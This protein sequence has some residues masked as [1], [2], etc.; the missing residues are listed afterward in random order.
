MSNITYFDYEKNSGRNLNFTDINGEQKKLLFQSELG[1]GTFSSNA[2]YKDSKTDELFAFKIYKIKNFPKFYLKKE[3]PIDKVKK[4]CQFWARMVNDNIPRLYY[5]FQKGETIIAMSELGNLGEPGVWNDDLTEFKLKD[6]VYDLFWEKVIEEDKIYHGVITPELD[7]TKKASCQSEE[8]CPLTYE[9]K[10]GKMVPERHVKSN[11]SFGANVNNMSE[12]EMAEFAYD[13]DL[14]NDLDFNFES[15]E[16]NIMS[17]DSNMMIGSFVKKKSLIL[18]HECSSHSNNWQEPEVQIHKE[19]ENLCSTVKKMYV[20]GRIFWDVCVGLYYMHKWETAHFD[21]KPN[22]IVISTKNSGKAMLIDFNTVE[23][24][25]ADTLFASSELEGTKI[26]AA[27]EA[28]F[29]INFKPEKYDMWGL[30]AVLY[31]FYYGKIA[32]DLNWCKDQEIEFGEAPKAILDCMRGLLKEDPED[33]WSWQQLWG[34]E[35]FKLLH[36][37]LD[38]MMCEKPKKPVFSS[39]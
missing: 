13:D 4:E 37:S 23:Q 31:A 18:H 16:M 14:F 6:D 9:K 34:C 10:V 5:W 11:D 36:L 35:L 39:K 7:L 24:Y 32:A 29:D 12:E 25:N 19:V 15:D 28:R 2:V 26:F 38:V 8:V 17:N 33:R 30:G 21:I 1:K 3:K 27:P 20:A 22:N